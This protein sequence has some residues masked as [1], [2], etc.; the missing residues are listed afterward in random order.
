MRLTTVHI[1]SIQEIFKQLISE[2]LV[3][4]RV[5]CLVTCL[6]FQIK[7][8]F[9]SKITISSKRSINDEYS[10][11]NQGTLEGSSEGCSEF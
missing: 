4:T 2:D 11:L 1:T 5:T 7:K 10:N 9:E 6:K 8:I 3:K